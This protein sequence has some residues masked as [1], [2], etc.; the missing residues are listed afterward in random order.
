MSSQDLAPVL[1]IHIPYKLLKLISA[2]LLKHLKLLMSRTG[3]II[4]LLKLT[5]P[6]F[7]CV[8]KWL[9]LLLLTASE[10]S[11]HIRHFLFLILTIGDS[12]NPVPTKTLITVVNTFWVLLCT[13]PHPECFIYINS[14]MALNIIQNLSFHSM[15]TARVLI[16][17]LTISLLRHKCLLIIVSHSGYPR[18]LVYPPQRMPF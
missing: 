13:S 1:Q 7:T 14:C 15:P 3:L 6:L 2:G 4:C 9:Q 11:Y 16:Q 12:E 10:M 5:S 8:G 17:G 18:P